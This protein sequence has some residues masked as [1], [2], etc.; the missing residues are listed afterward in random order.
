MS[1]IALTRY[2]HLHPTLHNK[3]FVFAR[4]TAICEEGIVQLVLDLDTVMLVLRPTSADVQT[5]YY[6]HSRG[7]RR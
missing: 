7:A 1:I 6:Q 3:S 2:K 4:P 5:R